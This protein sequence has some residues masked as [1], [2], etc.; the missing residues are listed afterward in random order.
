MLSMAKNAFVLFL[1]GRLFAEPGK[2]VTLMA[3]GVVFTALIC[4]GLALAGMPLWLAVFMAGLV[5]G[6][7]QP[8]LLK[9]VKFR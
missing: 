7:V 4:F 5:G 9:R 3:A 1:R 6:G 8:M 2:A